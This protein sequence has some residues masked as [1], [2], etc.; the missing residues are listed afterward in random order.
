[1]YGYI[2]NWREGWTFFLM[3]D[4]QFWRWEMFSSIDRSSGVLQEH[5]EWWKIEMVFG[6]VFAAT[7]DRGRGRGEEK[8]EEQH[9]ANSISIN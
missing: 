6:R 9:N 3:G 8:E 4:Q 5:P 7:G 2:R 1:M